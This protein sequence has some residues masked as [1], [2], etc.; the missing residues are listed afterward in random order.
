LT[1]TDLSLSLQIT[2]RL[3][4]LNASHW[5]LPLIKWLALYDGL[6]PFLEP[7]EIQPEDQLLAVLTDMAP[8]NDFL[9]ACHLV[10]RLDF[11]KWRVKFVEGD[12]WDPTEQSLAAFLSE[13]PGQTP[14]VWWLDDPHPAPEI[15]IDWLFTEIQMPRQYHLNG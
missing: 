13:K 10:A 6:A 8:M 2:S 12:R 9:M 5:Y 1:L 11:I 3:S 15:I 14:V 4:V 7:E